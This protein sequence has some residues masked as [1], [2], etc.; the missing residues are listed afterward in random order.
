MIWL[1]HHLLCL[2][3]KVCVHDFNHILSDK[4]C[5]VEVI[6]ESNIA[7]QTCEDLAR[8]QN[9]AA[10]QEG[11]LWMDRW[12]NDK[13]HGFLEHFDRDT[14]EAITADIDHLSVEEIT[15]GIS[16]ILISSAIVTFSKK[17]SWKRW[18]IQDQE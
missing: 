4:H 5:L 16:N 17:K 11:D 8:D 6:F 2:K 12:N 18:K 15:K 3:W 9:D 1:R 13:A 10:K 7:T 14:V